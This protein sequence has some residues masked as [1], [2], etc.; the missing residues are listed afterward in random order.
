MYLHED[1]ATFKE[2]LRLTAEE[3][4]RAISIVEKD[5]YVTMILRRLS[6]E[7]PHVVFKGGTSLSKGFHAINRFSEDIDITFDEH[8]GENRRKKLKNQVLLSISKELGMPISNWEETQSDRDYNAYFFSYE[9]AWGLNDERILSSVKLETALGSYAFPT[10]R[11]KIG[12]YVGDYLK[13][14]GIIKFIDK[15]NLD[16][17]EMKLQSIERTYIDKVF[18]LCD[19]YLQGKSKRYSRHLYD[20]YKLADLVSFDAALFLLY[21]EIREHRRNL[22]NCL[23]AEKTA[24]VS[25]IIREFCEKDFYKEDYYAI[26]NY[27]SEDMVEYKDTIGQMRRVADWIE[28]EQNK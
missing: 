1:K 27:F 21:E 4:G 18:A 19:Y 24:N 8:L 22:R 23:S 6:D 9:S 28:C 11:V 20:L 3:F 13:L 25:S 15:Y 5:Y 10:K 12:S 26:T 16:D 2:I 7:L 14:K 17:F